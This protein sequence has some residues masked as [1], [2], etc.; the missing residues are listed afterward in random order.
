MKDNPLA[1][2]EAAELVEQLARG[3]AAAH[4]VGILHRDLKP[5][6][7]L[8]AAD[9]TPKVTDFGLAKRFDDSGRGRGPG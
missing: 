2:R 7:V 9:G 1:G 6:N 3:V 8:F 4:A 5:E